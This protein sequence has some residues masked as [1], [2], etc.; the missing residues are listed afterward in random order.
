M[1]SWAGRLAAAKPWPPPWLAAIKKGR[2][3]GGPFGILGQREAYL[4]MEICC[5]VYSLPF[6]TFRV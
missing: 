3:V 4:T 5:M 1:S 6:F 2:P